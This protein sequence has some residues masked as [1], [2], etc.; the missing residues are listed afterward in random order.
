MTDLVPVGAGVFGVE[1]LED[2][3]ESDM[4]MP[5]LSLGSN[6]DAGYIIN[7]LSGEKIPGNPGIEMVVLGIVKNRI[8]WPP[9]MGATKENPLCRSYDFHV[10][11]PDPEQPARFPWAASGFAAPT[12][13]VGESPP[14]LS[15]EDCRLKEW[16]T[17]PGASKESPWCTEQHIYVILTLTNSTYA[18]AILTLQRSGIGPSRKYM[19]SYAQIKTPMFVATTLLT[20]EVQKRGTVEYSVPTLTRGRNTPETKYA[21]FAETYRRIRRV[22]QTPRSNDVDEVPVAAA[23]DANVYQPQAA[24][25]P[26]PQPVTPTAPSPVP[27]QNV[28][29]P[30]APSPAPVPVP[31]ETVPVPQAAPVPDI[32]PA[33]AAPVQPAQV[34]PQPAAAAPAPTPLDDDLPF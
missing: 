31:Q 34:I 28:A 30:A 5:R 25:A 17:N 29:P 2:F 26:A 19:S 16:G 4:V 9:E 18:S 27:V 13:V 20:L 33:A 1:G 12:L 23:P 11:H 8:L 32:P 3:D 22:L 15:C 24:P 7:N 10:G 6:Q 21:E 14:H